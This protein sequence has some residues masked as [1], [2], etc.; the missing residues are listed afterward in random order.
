MK[1]ALAML[2]GFSLIFAIW[3]VTKHLDEIEEKDKKL[4]DKWENLN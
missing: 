1:F 3:S 4:F 2:L